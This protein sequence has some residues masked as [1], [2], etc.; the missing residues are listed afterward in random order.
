MRKLA[1][2]VAVNQKGMTRKNRERLRPFNDDGIVANL[3]AVPDKIRRAVECS[4]LPARRAALQAQKAAAIAILL[5][6]PVRL[7]NLVNLDVERHLV[8]RDGKL[9][10]VVP[11]HEV[12]NAH[13]IDFELPGDTADLLAWYVREHR[14]CLLQSPSTALFPGENSTPKSAATLAVQIKNCVFSHTG[15][16]VNVHL[17]RHIAAKLYLDRSPGDY[18]TV[19]RVLG[20]RSLN[21]TT[22]IYTGM[23]TRAAGRHFVDVIRGRLA[24]GTSAKPAGGARSGGRP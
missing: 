2:K 16:E 18:V 24:A 8:E 23:E 12:K 11:E 17:F 9:Y 6:V 4:N 15:L 14:P 10:L 1:S 19:Q 5:V 20:H 21:T 22:T 7:R 3:Q 13:L